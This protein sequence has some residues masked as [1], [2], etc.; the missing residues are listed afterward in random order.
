LETNQP[1]SQISAVRT[2]QNPPKGTP[3]DGRIKNLEYLK[4]KTIALTAAAL[5][6]AA[7]SA[8][9]ASDHYG[10][11]NANQP[12]VDQTITSSVSTD[13]LGSKATPQDPNPAGQSAVNQGQ[14]GQGI[15]GR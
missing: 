9:A 13:I 15:W 5:F 14:Y 8:F 1:R 3:L 11:E 7:G 10:S 2:T 6:I 12:Y 4:M